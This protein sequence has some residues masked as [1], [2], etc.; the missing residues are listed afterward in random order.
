MRLAAIWEHFAT[1]LV[2]KIAITI[3]CKE[4]GDR[5]Y[6]YSNALFDNI[7]VNLSIDVP[8]IIWFLANLRLLLL[9]LLLSQYEYRNKGKDDHINTAILRGMYK[10]Q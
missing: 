2:D 7:A 1:A 3:T 4:I 5:F 9:L 10:H 6:V 8:G